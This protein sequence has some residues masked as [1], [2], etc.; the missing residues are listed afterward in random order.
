MTLT[1]AQ[2]EPVRDEL[3]R[4]FRQEVK[5]LD[6]ADSF[7]A[8]MIRN[9]ETSYRRAYRSIEDQLNAG[10]EIQ[11]WYSLVHGRKE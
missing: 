5:H 9:A 7:D 2:L 10:K 6:A 11:P 1:W 4:R 3:N 8:S